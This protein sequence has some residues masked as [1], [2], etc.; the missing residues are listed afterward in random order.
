MCRSRKPSTDALRAA[1]VAEAESWLR[2]PY[3]HRARIK[4][5][6]VDC[7]QILVGVYGNVGL[8]EP[9]DTGDYPMDWML[10]RDDERFLEWVRQHAHHEVEAN[11]QPGDIA[12]WRFGRCFSH[13][14]VVTAWPNVIH[15]HRPDRMVTRA[16]GTQGAL[17]GRAVK[18]FS[19]FE[20]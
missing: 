7:A 13:G 18:F 5:A 2:T 1:V 3:H 14:G 11:P 10:H 20:D 6:G 12:V 4:G 16:D 8:I 19:M 15:A 17:A 9:F